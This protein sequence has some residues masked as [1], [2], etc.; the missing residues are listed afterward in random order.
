LVVCEALTR[1][2]VRY[3]IVGEVAGEWHGIRMQ[4]QQI[5]LA[6]ERSDENV[7]RL[8]RALD[9]LGVATDVQ[10]LATRALL[11]LSTDAGVIALTSVGFD[12]Y[13]RDAITAD[14]GAGLRAPIASLGDVLR[15][16][17]H[18]RDRDEEMLAM[19]E[20]LA[21]ILREQGGQDT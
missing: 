2:G 21:D 14:L 19:L 18:R 13:A 15:T 9:E 3:V 1:H 16:S 17:L 7:A 12:D 5:E 10:A 8:T 11:R 4:T 6:Y 20:E